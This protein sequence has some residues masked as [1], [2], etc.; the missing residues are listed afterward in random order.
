MVPTV[1]SRTAVVDVCWLH[2]G[3]LYLMRSADS[4]DAGKTMARGTTSDAA[5]LPM[6]IILWTL[7]FVVLNFLVDVCW[8]HWGVLY[9]MSSADR[10][11]ARQT[12]ARGTTSDAAHSPMFIILWT[13]GFVVL[14]F[15][16]DV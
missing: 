9:L 13:L 10:M 6:F 3:V 1:T 15:L 11:D 4:M 12:M 5:H 7:G 14:I 16:V 2:W 8:L